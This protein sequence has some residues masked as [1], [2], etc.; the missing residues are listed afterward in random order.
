MRKLANRVL[1]LAMSVEYGE[2]EVEEGEETETETREYG[3][4]A[5][6]YTRTTSDEYV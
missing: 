5:K 4:Q 3:R 1:K 6:K 2:V